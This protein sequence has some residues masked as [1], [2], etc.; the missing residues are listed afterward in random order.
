MITMSRLTALG[1]AALLA[2]S[3]LG[4]SKAIADDHECTDEIVKAGA[5]Q[6]RKCKACHKLE[7]GKKGVGPHL[8]QIVGRGVADVEGYKYS[9]AMAAFGE[10]AEKVWNAELLH[11][12]LEKPKGLVKG[13]K[14]AFAGIKKEK[15]RKAVICYLEKNGG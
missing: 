3:P 1:L 7:D 14:M 6:Y 9:K 10:D 13:T 15:D 11:Q 5:K 2:A 8:F 12:Y 4:V